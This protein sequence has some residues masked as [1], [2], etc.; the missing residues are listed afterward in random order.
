MSL[1]VS[2][3]NE[4][5]H[6][7]GNESVNGLVTLQCF[8]PL[9]VE[10]VRLTLTGLAEA[11]IQKV[12]GSAAP[13]G[14][15]RSKCI[16]FEKV[17]ILSHTEGQ[18]FNTGIH[19]WPFELVFPS[20][21]EPQ[22]KETKWPVAA[23]FRSDSK[24]PLPPTFATQVED[25]SRRLK[26]SI[27]YRIHAQVFN[28]SSGFMK[29]NSEFLSDTIWLQ[30]RPPLSKFDMLD[31]ENYERIIRHQKEQTFHLRSMLLHQKHSGKILG[32]QE[33]FSSW[34]SP[35][36]LPQ[37]SFKV[38]FSYPA[39]VGQSTPLSCFL[40]I[41]P[42]MGD[43]SVSSPPVILLQSLHI[44]LV[45][46]TSTRSGPSIMGKMSGEVDERM[47]VLSTSSLNM[48]ISGTVDLTAKF[49]PLVFRPNPVSFGT[50]NISRT[51]RL[52]VSAQFECVGKV[53][54][55]Q[56][57]DMPVEIVSQIQ[58]NEDRAQARLELSYN[59]NP[60]V[61]TPSPA[62]IESAESPRDMKRD[63]NT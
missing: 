3:H 37:F 48:M 15:Y 24:H 9:E 28:P 27:G 34:L 53:L 30:F 60:P 5:P 10:E 63:E 62:G 45:S 38:S 31:A 40:D 13:S 26:C 51:Y 8:K 11:K 52:C 6:Y 43:S 39:R 42:L 58:E 19:S 16:L 32:L 47:I 4:L 49:G 22:L 20:N 59:D 50:Y 23:P 36:R 12:K 41:T 35:N 29:N 33:K 2:L 46:R 61:Y 17:I 25:A 54:K 18:P 21:A 56:A 55:F 7:S 57:P 44:T 1:K 14:S